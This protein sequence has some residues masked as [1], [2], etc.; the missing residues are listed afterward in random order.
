MLNTEDIDLHSIVIHDRLK[1]ISSTNILKYNFKLLY[2]HFN[3]I[4]YL[5]LWLFV[6]AFQFTSLL[7]ALL[8]FS[9][10]KI[11]EVN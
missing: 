5:A 11:L 8:S 2:V 1:F 9:Q 3:C 6:F 10:N 7:R 4:F